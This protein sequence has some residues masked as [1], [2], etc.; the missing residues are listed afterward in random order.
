[1]AK[2]RLRND[3]VSAVK[4]LQGNLANCPITILTCVNAKYIL[5]ICFWS[6]TDCSD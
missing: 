3:R 5:S 4:K 1:M 6:K 2:Q